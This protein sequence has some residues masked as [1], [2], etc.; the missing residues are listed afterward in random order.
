MTDHTNAA[1]THVRAEAEYRAME[2]Y[3]SGMSLNPADDL[4]FRIEWSWGSSC[5]GYK[6]TCTAVRR[7][8]AGPLLHAAIKEAYAKARMARDEALKQLQADLDSGG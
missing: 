3:I 7:H 8:L 4:G 2:T 1:L 5:T 6:E